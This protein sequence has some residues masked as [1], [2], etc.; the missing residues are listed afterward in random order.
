M[1]ESIYEKISE[2]KTEKE[3]WVTVQILYKDDECVKQMKLQIL[4]GEFKF[5]HMND[6]ESISD[7]FD[8]V[9]TILN[10]MWV[11]GEKLDD[12]RET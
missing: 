11:N 9:Q 8:Q 10:Q 1:D 5:L 3:A 2:A 7:Y 6:F 12:Q 4:K